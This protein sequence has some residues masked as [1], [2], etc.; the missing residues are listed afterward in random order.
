MLE[1]SGSHLT[2]RPLSDT[3]ER[4]L[5]IAQDLIQRRGFNAFSYHDIA[6]P[7]GIRKASIHYHFPSKADLG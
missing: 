6:A 3:A 2:E 7:M 5:D 4:I 1:N